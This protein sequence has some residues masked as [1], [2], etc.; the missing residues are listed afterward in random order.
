MGNKIPDPHGGGD[1]GGTGGGKPIQPGK[2]NGNDINPP[3]VGGKAPLNLHFFKLKA[4]EPH[5]PVC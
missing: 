3:D 5:P 4:A 1:G 2:P